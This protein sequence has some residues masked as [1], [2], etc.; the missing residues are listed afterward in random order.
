M[1]QLKAAHLAALADANARA[2]KGPGP[3]GAYP[4]PAGPYA[5]AGYGAHYRFCILSHVKRIPT[6]LYTLQNDKLVFRKI[7]HFICLN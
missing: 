3:A 6:L 7:E 5:P 4:G 2:P 1:A